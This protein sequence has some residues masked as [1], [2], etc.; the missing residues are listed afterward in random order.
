[1]TSE[2]DLELQPI[3]ENGQASFSKPLKTTAED[4]EAKSFRLKPAY[5]SILKASALIG[6]W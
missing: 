6:T 3:L 4:E 5:R 2:N 1:M